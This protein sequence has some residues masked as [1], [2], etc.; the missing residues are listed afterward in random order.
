MDLSKGLQTT[1]F[2]Y[3]TED[4]SWIRAVNAIMNDDAKSVSNERGMLSIKEDDY[5]FLGSIVAD[6][7]VFIFEQKRGLTVDDTKFRISYVDLSVTTP[8][9]EVILDTIYL[10]YVLDDSDLTPAELAD[11]V[12]DYINVIEG[13]FTYNKSKERIILWGGGMFM[14][15]HVIPTTLG[16]VNEGVLDRNICVLNV[17][18]LSFKH[19]LNANKEIL[20]IDGTNG[21][22]EHLILF[23]NPTI[24]VPSLTLNKISYSGG[25]LKS[26]TYYIGIQYGYNDRDWTNVVE[27]SRAISIMP[28]TQT[29]SYTNIDGGDAGVTTGKSISLN[30][31]NIDSKYIKFRVIVYSII[32]GVHKAYID[33][34][35]NIED[36]FTGA[37]DDVIVTIRGLSFIEID[38]NEFKIDTAYINTSRS[39]SQFQNRVLLSNVT[40]DEQ[41]DLQE[42]A[43]GFQV[44]YIYKDFVSIDANIGSHKDAVALYNYKT[45]MP[46]EVVALYVAG[47][48][49]N[50]KRTAP[51]HIPGRESVEC[52]IVDL[53]ENTK[54]QDIPEGDLPYKY[55]NYLLS[56]DMDIKLFHIFSVDAIEDEVGRMTYWENS[57][58]YYPT[59]DRFNGARDLRG[60]KV[61][62][63]KFPEQINLNRFSEKYIYDSEDIAHYAYG[64]TITQL[65]NDCYTGGCVSYW[66]L[67][68][69]ESGTRDS[70]AVST[71]MYVTNN[72]I[73]DEYIK[74]GEFTINNNLI[75][76]AWCYGINAVGN[77][78]REEGD[79]FIDQFEYVIGQTI[80]SHGSLYYRAKVP[81]VVNILDSVIY[82]PVTRVYNNA[83]AEPFVYH[84]FTILKAKVTTDINNVVNTDILEVIYDS[85]I[86]YIS[87]RRQGIT[88]TVR[89]LSGLSITQHDVYLDTDEYLLFNFSITAGHSNSEL[90]QSSEITLG[91]DSLEKV[92]EH[93]A[94]NVAYTPVYNDILE[95]SRFGKILGLN[96]NNIILPNTMLDDLVGIEF[97][98]AKRTIETAT[99]I[100]D[101]SP[102]SY[103][104]ITNP[105]VLDS[106]VRIHPFDLFQNGKKN[107]PI[108]YLLYHTQFTDTDLKYGGSTTQTWLGV[109]AISVI[110]D[111]KFMIQDNLKT[112]PS[113]VGKEEH[114]YNSLT[115]VIE[116]DDNELLITNM[117]VASLGVFK[118]NV[119]LPFDTQ[120]LVR[121]GNILLFTHDNIEYYSPTHFK[122]KDGITEA[123]DIYGGDT[124]FNISAT[125]ITQAVAGPHAILSIPVHSIS[126]VGLRKGD[127]DKILYYPRNEAIAFN[128]LASDLSI[129]DAASLYTSWDYNQDYSELNI[130]KVPF[131]YKNNYDYISNNYNRIVRS[132]QQGIQ[133]LEL[134]WRTF[135]VSDYYELDKDKG[136]I[137]ASGVVQDNFVINAKNTVY[138]A[139]IKDV[140][141]TGGNDT[142]LGKGDLF[143]REPLE[144]MTSD[145]GYAGCTHSNST[146]NTRVGYVFI[147]SDRYSI[148]MFTGKELTEL[149][150]VG[151]KELVD[152]IFKN[153]PLLTD[154]ILHNKGIAI[155]HDEENSRL[156]FNFHV[157]D[158]VAY[159]TKTP[160]DRHPTLAFDLGT[161]R[162]ISYSDVN[163]SSFIQGRNRLLSVINNV[164]NSIMFEHNRNLYGLYNNEQTHNE[165]SIDILFNNKETIKDIYE[166]IVWETE[167]ISKSRENGTGSINDANNE[168]LHYD[169]TFTGIM[170]YNDTQCSEVIEVNNSNINEDPITGLPTVDWQDEEQGRNNNGVWS[171]NDFRDAVINNKLKFFTY[172]MEPTAN[173]DYALKDWQDESN[174]IGKYI[175]VRLIFNNV[176]T[177]EDDGTITEYKIKVN[178]VNINKRKSYK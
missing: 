13:E 138:V 129:V 97:Y 114:I 59:T 143:D 96:I 50:G 99:R 120:E 56:V 16:Y 163:I 160:L 17:D 158:G 93:L 2:P 8:T 110:R 38:V 94:L 119:Y 162:W 42:S 95:G 149:N 125:K 103:T 66:S 115:D 150:N 92:M 176:P 44:D 101:V 147:D 168:L 112:I 61:K 153:Y 67:Y 142:Y 39:I 55:K 161:K 10:R 22:N 4:G 83:P 132:K 3:K 76:S 73:D 166:A 57:N 54:I 51:V 108:N 86:S 130:L 1:G 146:L 107:I 36:L 35:Y 177:L 25:V 173:V 123:N 140:L 34:E 139:K 178:D 174:F 11:G 69:D 105:T 72:G 15:K 170:I 43:I 145:S 53:D 26:G 12:N 155:A 9:F 47:I 171:F 28:G 78:F 133:D 49:P 5:L 91:E 154:D 71:N 30:V 19:G 21:N 165:F 41:I 128:T 79:P 60:T 131:P 48:Y 84:R 172:D 70:W 98:Y 109:N 46:G 32:A 37:I 7:G 126:N 157:K 122:I 31:G 68:K 88:P 74:A 82:S 89:T 137:V 144:V 52:N 33:S 6:D 175:V 152:T 159:N 121:T 62:H 104:G 58:E 141:A 29:S 167:V 134:N 75:S 151:I 111:S 117:A 106:N 63:H 20:G 81:V 148:F 135:K 23:Q 65:H 116:Q 136:I 100:G 118:E 87:F 18:N 124:Y 169:K 90:S 80:T 77:A 164:D 85:G 156:L 102:L 24:S 64:P 113:T 40:Y 127:D 27:V 45:F 14:H